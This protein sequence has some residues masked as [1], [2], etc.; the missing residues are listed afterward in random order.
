MVLK[1]SNLGF[2]LQALES[3]HV[4]SVT[5]FTMRPTVI[6][7]REAETASSGQK[8]VLKYH[9]HGG[10]SSITLEEDTDFVDGI[11]GTTWEGA[12]LLSN[13]LENLLAAADDAG[14]TAYK[15]H[16]LELGCGTGVVGIT[17]AHLGFKTT[18]SDRVSD[19]AAAN[20][21]RN[22]PPSIRR[23]RRSLS[24]D[25]RLTKVSRHDQ[26]DEQL[27]MNKLDL[28]DNTNNTSSENA[29][30]LEAPV[31]VINLPWGSSGNRTQQLSE[32]YQAF[33]KETKSSTSSCNTDSNETVKP[34]TIDSRPWWDVQS[35]IQA[36]GKVDIVVGAE[37]TCLRK[38]H[39]LL[40]ETIIELSNSNPQLLA[41]FSFDGLYDASS[42]ESAASIYEAEFIARMR[43]AGFLH[44][45]V[46]QANIVWTSTS[47]AP[48]HSDRQ[49]DNS[50][51]SAQQPRSDVTASIAWLCPL[52][53]EATAQSPATAVLSWPKPHDGNQP[54]AA[55]DAPQPPEGEIFPHH[56]LAF[57]RHSA[58]LTCVHCHCSYLNQTISSSSSDDK[59]AVTSDQST[60]QSTGRS[61]QP[62]PLSSSTS[63]FNPRI[64]GQ[65]RVH[66]GFFVCRRHPAEVRLS[67]DGHG[68]GLGYYGNGAEGWDAVFWDCCGSEDPRCPGCVYQAHVPF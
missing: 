63:L 23:K 67:I 3:L 29:T 33:A 65:C 5:T 44:S 34:P 1:S 41:L 11:G 53:M 30:D 19:L 15:H 32:Q 31:V 26:L 12:F 37:I 48:S 21:T 40:L 20:L 62:T 60:G 55:I 10:R 61:D 50:N 4:N 13:V 54:A 58:A 2:M 45:V 39:T 56:V 35:L 68:D 18:I 6:G 24:G 49:R 7:S 52:P 25:G 27:D 8:A 51:P 47:P 17:A 66:P 9:I 16:V 46:A 59:V 38:Q 36:R 14:N 57:Y 22:P 64:Q 28:D 43:A 42:T